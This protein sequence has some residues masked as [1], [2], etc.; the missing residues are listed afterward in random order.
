MRWEPGFTHCVVRTRVQKPRSLQP[1]GVILPSQCAMK[2]GTL[3]IV[4]MWL[5]APPR[6]I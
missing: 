1:V 2:T 5:V 6:I 4:R 3:A